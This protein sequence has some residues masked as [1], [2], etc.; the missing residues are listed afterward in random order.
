MIV[1]RFTSMDFSSQTTRP[2]PILGAN[3][4]VGLGVPQ[5][6]SDGDDFDAL[7]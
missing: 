2:N 7:G 5:S 1:A 4:N 6:L 3:G